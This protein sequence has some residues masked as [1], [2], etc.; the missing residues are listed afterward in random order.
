[1]IN[2]NFMFLNLKR[3]KK[4]VLE[5]CARP[6]KIVENIVFIRSWNPIV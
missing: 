3:E 6:L 1:M 2:E 4:V 5:R